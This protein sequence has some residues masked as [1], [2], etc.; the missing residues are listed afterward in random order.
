MRLSWESLIT[1]ERYKGGVYKLDTDARTEFER[2]LDRIIFSSAFRRLKDKTQLFPVPKSDFVHTR[3]THSIEVASIGRSLGK[4]VGKFIL[5]QE[6]VVNSRD[7]STEITAD[8]F[9]HIVAAACSAH[10]IGNPPF[11]HSGEQSFRAFFEE[12]FTQGDFLERY[13]LTHEES[14]D[15]KNFEG[16]AEGFRILTNDHPSGIPGGLKLTYTTLAAFTK[17]PK[18]AGALTLN[19]SGKL[20][21][22]RRS[23]KKFGFFQQE[24]EIFREIADKLGL[25]RLSEGGYYWCRHPLAF[26]VEAADNISYLI[27]DLEDGHKLRLISADDVVSLLRPIAT[28]IP[29]DPC[30]IDELDAIGNADERVGAYRAK[31]INSLIYQCFEVFKTN[32]NDIMRAK[33]DDELTN[34]IKL[35]HELTEI[36]NANN[37]F[38]SY[39]KVVQIESGGRHVIGGLLRIY[40]DAYRNMNK[41][42][43]RNII[44]NLPQQFRILSGTPP[45]EA[46]L[47]ISGYISRMTDNFAINH[48]RVLTGHKL[49]EIL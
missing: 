30:S 10:D 11:G 2:D 18:Q 7:P 14:E 26:L 22:K 8:D 46:L 45:Y 36:K 38:F 25:I 6:R 9:G 40:F 35:S 37:K 3:M 16:N 48:Y 42:Y 33:Y 43:G 24:K 49:P 31:A 39:D 1:T 23:A 13:D 29:K 32:Y 28:Q 12:Q 17:Y 27:M 47:K 5:E 34:N 20:C 41:A 44:D 21:D 15:F 4:L 19:D